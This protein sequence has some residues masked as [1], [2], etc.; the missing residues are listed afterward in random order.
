MDKR[1]DLNSYRAQYSA[2]ARK[3]LQDLGLGDL[4]QPERGQLLASI[5]SYT[6]QVLTNE[7]LTNLR[8][9]DLD[10]AE[11]ILAN[12]GDEEEMATYLVMNVP[13]IELKMGEAMARTYAR[14]MAECKQ[15]AAAIKGRDGGQSTDSNT[16]KAN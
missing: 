16:E 10:E 1:F 4:P 13:E 11:A 3:I 15:L 12:G 9:A 14:L 6:Q 7:L 8:P 5:E 2:Y